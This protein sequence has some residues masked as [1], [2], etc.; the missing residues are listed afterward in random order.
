MRTTLVYSGRYHLRQALDLETLAAV[1]RGAGHEV[2]LAYN[3]DTFGVTDNVFQIPRLGRWL[4]R[5]REMARRIAAERADV[6]LFSV[7]PNTYEWCVEVASALKEQAA[8]PVGALGLHPTLAPERVLRAPCIDFALQGEVETAIL[9]LLD[10]LAGERE[11]A[12]VGNLW[13]RDEAGRP[14]FTFRAPLVDLDALP[15]PD[16]DLFVPDVSHAY[17]Y[18]A[19]VSRGC[20]Y[21]CSFCEETCVR[22]LY[23][24]GYFRR[25]R[26]DT[27]MRE[28]T[29]GKRK[30][31]FSEV[32][33]KDSYLSGDK[34]WLRELMRRYREEVGV[35]FKCFCTILGFDN[36]TAR[37]LAEGGCYSIE[38]GLQTWNPR[39]RHDVLNRRETNAQAFEAF[40][41]CEN[42]A[43]WFDVDHMFNLPGESEDDHIA[44]ALS[45]RKLRYLNR[46][47][48]HF[49]VYL[50]GAG[51]VE[52]GIR[53]GDLPADIHELLADGFESDFYDQ[54]TTDEARR[55][56]V[57]GYA[58]LYKLLPALPPVV[59]DWLLRKQ[60][61]RHLR[62]I[63][64][65]VMA[66]LQGLLALRS[67]D[68]R[69]SAYLR[70]YPRKIWKTLAS[71]R[72][73]RQGSVVS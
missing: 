22:N 54:G 32:I 43:L 18:V 6:V 71:G 40:R 15:L 44:G 24:K 49:L 8:V 38:F 58:A 45:Y 52:E 62:H 55:Q 33:F 20:P 19:M 2:S 11:R 53:A 16:K 72:Y 27:V 13:F 65:P 25:K 9:P 10:A 23:G 66:T 21:L 30:Y 67:G 73:G 28:L 31:G 36:E 50:P 61:V 17:S 60:R 1:L 48:V 63:P 68:R 39:I 14:A 7:L 34:A 4:S 56:L 51:I 5:P 26:V 41:H 12:T 69:F 29:E 37:I 57:A 42:H 47:K 3:P 59:G 70:L 46:I 64:A 35:P